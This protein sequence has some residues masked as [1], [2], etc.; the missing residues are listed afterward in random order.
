MF[1]NREIRVVQREMISCYR[2]R[3]KVEAEKLIMSTG[4]LTMHAERL[5]GYKEINIVYMKI[6]MTKR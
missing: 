1:D 2:K 6:K 5:S 4:S 3:L